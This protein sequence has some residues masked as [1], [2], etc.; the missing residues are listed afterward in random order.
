MRCSTPRMRCVPG[1]QR[2]KAHASSPSANRS[3]DGLGEFSPWSRSE[4]A[5]P[6]RPPWQ[7]EA[8]V[9]IEEPALALN[10]IRVPGHIHVSRSILVR[11]EDARENLLGAIATVAAGMPYGRLK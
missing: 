8:M 6:L 9:K 3:A 11:P 2:G 10:D 4:F 1:S 7:D 5:S